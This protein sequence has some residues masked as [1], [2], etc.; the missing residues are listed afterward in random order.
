[1][2]DT[3]IISLASLKEQA[4]LFLADNPT[5][6]IE[7]A[8]GKALARMAATQAEL[9]AFDDPFKGLIIAKLE[10][11]GARRRPVRTAML[12]VE[13]NGTD[14]WKLWY[15]LRALREMG[16]VRNLGKSG[17]VLAA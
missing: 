10:A 4:D 3:L 5:M 7:E 2:N 14:T 16:L 12:S 1:M 6:T 17:W 15:H 11:M 9:F 13:L 8:Y